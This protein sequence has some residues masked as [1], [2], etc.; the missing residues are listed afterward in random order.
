MDRRLAQND[1]INTQNAV[2]NFVYLFYFKK[3]L[4][5]LHLCIIS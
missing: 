3:I 4:F 2:L 5:N 1:R